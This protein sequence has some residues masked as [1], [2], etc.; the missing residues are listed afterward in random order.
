VIPISRYYRVD[1]FFGNDPFVD[2]DNRFADVLATE[3]VVEDNHDVSEGSLSLV[4]GDILSTQCCSGL[5]C[6]RLTY[7]MILLWIWMSGLMMFLM[8]A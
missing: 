4:I 6:W 3:S 7:H 5:F 1:Y 2:L 8:L